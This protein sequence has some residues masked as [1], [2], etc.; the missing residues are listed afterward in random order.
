VHQVGTH[1]SKKIQMG[2]IAIAYNNIDHDL[3][4]S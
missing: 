3:P 2:F 1:L 4:R